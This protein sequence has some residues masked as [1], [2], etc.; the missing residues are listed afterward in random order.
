[1]SRIFLSHSSQDDVAAV[2]IRDW[3][4][5]NGWNDVFLDLDPAL[6][7]HPGERWERALYEHATRC[8][9]VLF[10]VSHNWLSSDWCRREYELA[11]KLNK[12]IFV[13][14]IDNITIKDL[15]SFLTET[16][17]AVSLA[18]GSDHQWRRVTL[19]GTQ[20][21]H[22]VTFSTDG[23]A[24]LKAGLT[25]A[26]LDPRF[27][28]WPPENEPNRAPY[29]GL[30][31]LE[32]VDAGIFFGRD[33]PVIEA[34]D[35]LRA[36]RDGASPRLFVI[37]GASGAGKSSFLRAGLLPRLA[38]DD[39]AFLAVAAIRPERAAITGVNGLVAVLAAACAEKGLS[40]TRGD[41][42]EAAVKGAAALRPYLQ[43]LASHASTV[44]ANPRPP[45][46]VIAVD[47]AEEIFRAEG[48][49][50][51]ESL[52][53]LLRDLLCADDPAVIALFVIRS[54]SYDAL[55]HAKALEGLSQKAFP[56]LP[57]PRGAYQTVIEG[58]SKRMVQAGRKFEI[59]PSLTQALLTDLQA[60]G[61]SD[62]LPLLAFTLEQLYLDHEAA[63]RLTYADYEHFGG[64]KGA[65]DATI[66]RV[67]AEADKDARIPKDHDARLVLLRRGLIPWLAGIDPETKTPRRRRAPV[68]Q[69]P[70]EA[71]PLLDLLVE[72][73]LLIRA[74]DDSS[75]EITVEPAH[76]ALLRQWGDLKGWLAED[77]ARLVTLEGV[78]RAARDWD[79]NAR[80][81]AWAAHTDARLEEADRLDARPDLAALLNSTD[82]AYLAAC[83]EKQSEARAKELALAAAERRAARRTRI[84]L[85]VSCFLAILAI[86]AAVFGLRQAVVARDQR[87]NAE[88]QAVNAE[89]SK[90]EAQQQALNAERSKK[91]AEQQALRAQQSKQV[92]EQQTLKAEQRSAVLAANVSRSLTTEGSIDQAL[93]LM[94]DAARVFDDDT[95]PDEIRIAFTKA[96]LN[97]QSIATR[98]LFPHMRVF[99]TDD[100][101]LLFD[102]A[103]KDIWKL[104]DSIDPKQFL[105]G[106]PGDEDIL[107][108]RQSADRK[109]YIV[110]RTDLK[111]ELINATTGARRQIGSFAEPKAPHGETYELGDTNITDDGLIVRQFATY[112]G[113]DPL[114]IKGEIDSYFQSMDSQS[115]TLLEGQ[116]VGIDVTL[117]RKGPV[118]GVY[119][120][121]DDDKGTQIFQINSGKDGLVAKAVRLNGRTAVAVQFGDCIAGMPSALQAKVIKV[122][123][124]LRGLNSR[125]ECKKFGSRY[126]ITEIYDT[127]AG[128]ERS[129]TLYRPDGKEIDV[130]GIVTNSV[131]EDIRDNNVAWVGEFPG[132]R[133]AAARPEKDWLGVLLNR[134]AYVLE[135]NPDGDDPSGGTKGWSLVLDYRHPGFVTNGRF[136][137]TGGLIAV[138]PESGRIVMHDF[139]NQSMEKLFSS[140]MASIIGTEQPVET[141]H[142]GSCVG[143]STP[144]VKSERMPDGDRIVFETASLTTSDENNKHQLEIAGAKKVI[145]ALGDDARC[146]EFSDDWKKMLIVKDSVVELYDFQK[147]LETGKLAGNELGIL[148]SEEVGSAFFVGFGGDSILMADYTNHVLLWKEV[149]ITKKWVSAEVYKGDNVV[150]YA[151]PDAT[152]Q[153]IILIEDVGGGDEHGMLYS[154]PARQVW[155]DLGRDYK[156][157]GATFA[158]QSDVIVSEHWT[159]ARAF[160]MLPLSGLAALGN[161]E[162]SPE[163]RPRSPNQYRSSPCWP[164]S[165]Q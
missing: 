65:I 15:P 87:A 158:D 135:H 118:G 149:P 119:G 164:A 41:L 160:P 108:L 104:T 3:L 124:S 154:V 64:L 53:V 138:D 44:S 132:T 29:R 33:A 155:F 114:N 152:G 94:L 120:I 105:T 77:F 76:E 145:V 83:R 60:G 117:K 121:A 161:K 150:R 93:L 47:Q 99:E 23:L 39:S 20:E 159:W 22:N 68:T 75:H 91:D 106:S 157:L 126:L 109:S 9:A 5:E 86:G 27:F 101:L 115:G 11:R 156:W 122:H 143:Y 153:R 66:T 72:Q 80:N 123:D 148:R 82:R 95:V 38:R 90:I 58:P 125:I 130:K 13:V 134:N 49:Q 50:E 127:T 35:A 61:G 69:I 32:A 84:A 56:L 1:M 52:L 28:A 36:L 146:V 4:N 136:V 151:E 2:A 92:A 24:R 21:E 45:T 131:S 142:H 111:V 12:R 67:F 140:S 40:T 133:S 16:H 34:L 42:R 57:M 112:R 162:L 10:L 100:A 25:Q 30:E 71:H 113:R 147:I 144:P 79:A 141:L 70:D 46:L 107:K 128:Q 14:L 78:Q 129:D 88:R 54:D 139:G 6:G 31:P 137:A 110:L 165:Y 7:I 8:E 163:C 73:R 96:L 63:G 26:G 59:D 48:A 51:G 37:L 55:E 62:A 89:E 18:S 103:T 116:L 102:P 81:I 97:R 74:V 85:A 98:T 43:E 17:Q 19:P